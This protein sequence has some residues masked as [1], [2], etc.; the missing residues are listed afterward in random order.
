MTK[1]K[2]CIYKSNPMNDAWKD[3]GFFAPEPIDAFKNRKGTY[4][5]C[6]AFKQSVNDYYAIKSP[7]DFTIEW[8][9]DQE[10]LTILGAPGLVQERVYD[11][12]K[13]DPRL[14]TLL[15]QYIFYAEKDVNA[16]VFTPFFSE[17][18]LSWHVLPGRYNVGA[19]VR[20]IDVTIELKTKKGKMKV[21]RGDVL[22]Y[23][24][25]TSEKLDDKFDLEQVEFNEKIWQQ[26]M[27]CTSFKDQI[28]YL[29]LQEMYKVFK[30]SI[31]SKMHKWF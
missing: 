22:M 23:V 19:W 6:P 7:V 14:V 11:Q 15:F 29:S 21:K 20:P 28:K 16:E 8:S 18:P 2:W 27:A 24:K 31:V 30:K 3:L 5:A 12:G 9:E 4:K 10:H 1:I 25:F 13:D 17:E 26:S